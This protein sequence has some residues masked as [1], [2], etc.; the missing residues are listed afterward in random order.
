MGALNL[1]E[2]PIRVK[3]VSSLTAGLHDAN[4]A[5]THFPANHR[6]KS[7]LPIRVPNVSRPDVGSGPYSDQLRVP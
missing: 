7:M 3:P 1:V 2:D 5:N 4:L 6:P